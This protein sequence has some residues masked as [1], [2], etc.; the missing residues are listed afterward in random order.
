MRS[1]QPREKPMNPLTDKHNTTC[2]CRTHRRVEGEH[3]LTSVAAT[4]TRIKN[5]MYSLRGRTESKDWNKHYE[6][7]CRTCFTKSRHHGEFPQQLMY[8]DSS[9]IDSVLNEDRRRV[10]AHTRVLST[11]YFYVRVSKRQSGPASF[12]RFSRRF[13]PHLRV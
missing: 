3:I 11:L 6:S 2:L 9:G 5:V 8:Q 12:A 10:Y 4:G 1:L 7:C 13:R